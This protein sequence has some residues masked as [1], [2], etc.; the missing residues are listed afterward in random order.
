MG[1]DE[2]LEKGISRRTALKRIGTAG[3]IA[4]AT[5]V[6]SSLQTPAFAA[7]AP[8][9]TCSECP[10]VCTYPFPQCGNSGPQGFCGCAQRADGGGCFCFE[11]DFCSN[12]TRC[13][14]GQSDC[15]G[16]QV[17]IHTCCDATDG[18][19]LCFGPCAPDGLAPRVAASASAGT[20]AT[21]SHR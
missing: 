9:G 15:S 16:D 10:S 8:P 6:I 21:G 13:P 11:D 19:P 7:T 1:E 4:W 14:N 20:G 18:T 3:A 5:P 12:R 17:C 2:R